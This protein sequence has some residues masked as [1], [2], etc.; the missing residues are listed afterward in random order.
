MTAPLFFSFVGSLVICMALIPPLMSSAGR[1]NI[2]DMPGDRKLHAVPIARVGG[3]AF[4][5]GTF[6]AVLLWAPKEPIVFAY[7]LGGAAILLF[8]VWDDRA[9]LSFRMKFIGQLIA[10]GIVVWYGDV[11]LTSLPLFPDLA[12]PDWASV[13]LTILTIL[14][15]TNAINLADG[16]D[17][18]AGGLTLLSFSGIAYLAYV[19][20]DTVV[21][22]MMLSVL[23][24]LLGFLR[25]NTYP[26][27][28][29]MGDGG[30]QFLGF[31]L[32][33]STIMLTDP[34][35]GPYSP[36]LGLLIIGLPLLDTLGVM[37]Q[38]LGERR[39]PFLADNNHIHH[40]LLTVGFLQH[41]AVLLIYAIQ[42]LMVS[43]ACGLRW[44]SDA[45]LLGIYGAIAVLVLALFV[46][47]TSG[48]LRR[49]RPHVF[50]DLRAAWLIHL[51]MSAWLTQTPLR[52]VRI[53]LLLFLAL[54]VFLPREVPSDFGWLAAI[55]AAVLIFSLRMRPEAAPW[56]IRAC[57]YVG[58]AFVLFLSE[59]GAAGLA[60]PVQ[61]GINLWFGAMA[62]LVVLALR[63]AR[64]NR[65]E[66]TPLDY[67]MVFLALVIPSLPE[68]RVG[69]TPVNLLIAK[70][71]V[72]FF[73]YELLMNTASPRLKPL[74]ALSLWLLIG[75]G[76]RAWM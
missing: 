29:F 2:L 48:H 19:S 1:F 32:G 4:A 58:S 54:S 43:L 5:L 20:G 70:L 28:V 34:S 23:G 64:E 49:W 38:R 18:L 17:G 24:G 40:K 46:L 33:V 61:A 37:I 14:G 41:E 22:F 47:A 39:S 72:L 12:L 63:F 16:L 50:S 11:R 3:I 36:A 30:S 60:W 66:T 56:I 52:F 76:V 65:F 74:G 59:R 25:F 13:L 68:M 21:M 7:L 45:V 69:D 9:G 27:R 53:G 51:E 75:L 31:V 57:L 71:I 26:A 10:A 67:L 44:Q 6:T 15:V 73:A 42:A 55:L 35:R 62:V 8:G